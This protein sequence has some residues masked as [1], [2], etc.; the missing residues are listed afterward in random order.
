MVGAPMYHNIQHGNSD[1]Q[2][3]SH[4]MWLGTVEVSVPNSNNDYLSSNA[5]SVAS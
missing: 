2:S 1:R 5:L 3:A 4:L